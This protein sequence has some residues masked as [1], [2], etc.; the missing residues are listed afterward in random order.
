MTAIT[1]VQ[2]DYFIQLGTSEKDVWTRQWRTAL[3]MQI[4]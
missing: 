2:T 4:I 1:K 3:D